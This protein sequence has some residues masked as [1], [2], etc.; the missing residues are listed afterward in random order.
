MVIL[1]APKRQ[2]AVLCNLVLLKP[3]EYHIF[4]IIIIT[5]EGRLTLQPVRMTLL[6]GK[7]V[8]VLFSVIDSHKLKHI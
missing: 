5:P 3:V 7:S 2:Y 6:A 1:V 8:L 4:S